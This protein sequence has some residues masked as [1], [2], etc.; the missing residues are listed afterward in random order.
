MLALS[1]DQMLHM[2]GG[3]CFHGGRRSGWPCRRRPGA[4][5]KGPPP[6]TLYIISLAANVITH[7]HMYMFVHF[8]SMEMIKTEKSEIYELI[9]EKIYFINIVYNNKI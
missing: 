5:F 4:D 1:A 2:L 9:F 6:T 8:I 7:L 3:T